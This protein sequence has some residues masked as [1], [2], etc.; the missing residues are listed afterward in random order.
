MARILFSV[1]LSFRWWVVVALVAVWLTAV[2][3]A[4]PAEDIRA[5]LNANFEA[6]NH[7]NVPAMMDTL[8]PTLP[9]RD[10]FAEHAQRVFDNADVYIRVEDFELLEVRGNMAKARVV[11]VTLP[12]SEVQDETKDEDFFRNNSALL[13]DAERVEYVQ[14]F[15]REGGKWRLWLIMSQPREPFVG[16]TDDGVYHGPNAAEIN[17]KNGKFRKAD[18]PNGNCGFPR[19]KVT[20]R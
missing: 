20:S 18:C 9:D 8:S 17:A 5:A 2:A 13:P 7:E 3:R 6:Y 4:E 1:A 15:K 14:G 16:Y 10:T 12:A 19:V 11:Q